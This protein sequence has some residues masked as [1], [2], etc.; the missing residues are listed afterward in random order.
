MRSLRRSFFVWFIVASAAQALVIDTQ[1]DDPAREA[2]AQQLFHELRCVVCEGQSL[3]ES[4]AVFAQQMRQAIRDRLDHGDSSA[5][6]RDYF[7]ERYGAQIL[8]TPPLAAN[9]YFLWA[10]PVLFLLI[11][12]WIMRPRHRGDRP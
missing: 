7:V 8:Q 12:A 6:V 2:E 11:A 5:Q 3:A 1:L 9:T 4:D 10:M